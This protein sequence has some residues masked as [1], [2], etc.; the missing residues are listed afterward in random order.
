MRDIK[1]DVVKRLIIG[2]GN[3][4]RADDGL[5]W[6]FVEKIKD[7]LPD[8]FDYE[9]RYQLQVEDSELICHYDTVIFVDATKAS[10]SSGFELKPC[11]I[12]EHYYFSSHAQNPETVVYLA[13]T[14]YEVQPKAYVLGI[15]GK[16]WELGEGLSADAE[17]NLIRAIDHFIS[18]D[19]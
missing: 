16:E 11:E 12:A 1:T 8:A 14:L 6:T 15:S 17:L 5:G 2:I 10:H 3:S 13:Q 19:W 9:L 7:R 18:L 4:A